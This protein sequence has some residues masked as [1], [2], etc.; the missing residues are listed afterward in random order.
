[1]STSF[2]QTVL[3]SLTAV[4][5]ALP[6][7]SWSQAAPKEPTVKPL[8]GNEPAFC[9]VCGTVIAIKRV[10]FNEALK[11]NP[12]A[13]TTAKGNDKFEVVI[14]LDAGT[15]QVVTLDIAPTVKIGQKVKIVNGVVLPDVA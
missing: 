6:V 1:M 9:D 7:A 3:L 8:I 10:P 12:Q 4:M 15:Q 5:L 11:K 2:K 13:S 14:R